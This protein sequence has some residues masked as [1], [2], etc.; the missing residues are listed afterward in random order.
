MPAVQLQ[1]PNCSASFTLD[2]QILGPATHCPRCGRSF[3]PSMVG[4]STPTPSAAGSQ[5]LQAGMTL[6]LPEQFGRYRILKRLGQGGMGAVFLAHDTQLDRRVALKIPYFRPWDD[7]GIIDRF[8]REARAAATLDHPNLCPIYEVGQI[9]GIHYLT[10]PYLAGKLLSKI[11]DP[12]NPVPT[13]QAVAVVRKLALALQEAHRQGIIHRDLKPENIIASRQREFVI[14]DFGLA[15]RLNQGDASLTGSGAI[16]GTPYY[17]A[18]EQIDGDPKTIGPACDIYS[19]GVILYQLLTGRRPFEGPVTMVLARIPVAPPPPP[20]QFRPDLDPALE[21]ICLKA[22]AKKPENR[23][24]SM[25]EFAAALAAYHGS[26]SGEFPVALS[27]PEAAG[28]ISTPLSIAIEPTPVV[29]GKPPPETPNPL[30]WAGLGG[31]RGRGAAG[32]DPFSEDEQGHDRDCTERPGGNG[33]RHDRRRSRRHQGR[34]PEAACR[35]R[36]A[37]LTARYGQALREHLA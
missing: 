11:I 19:L 34:R 12:N 6:D 24:A 35:D 16:L 17:M 36:D 18:P 10:M 33:R 9:D 28:L 31:G 8:Y 13:Q 1:C 25:A 23:F 21:S 20:S 37:P 4:Q 30:A 22:L 29:S 14:M 27:S 3:N 32:R 2:S 26:T 7:P 15:R 5:S